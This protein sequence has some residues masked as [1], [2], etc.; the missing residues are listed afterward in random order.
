MRHTIRTTLPAVG[1]LWALVAAGPEAA[2][3]KPAAG[4]MKHDAATTGSSAVATEGFDAAKKVEASKDATEAKIQG[5]GLLSTGN[6]DSFAATGLAALR[7]RR[8]ENEFSASAAVNYSGTLADDGPDA[9]TVENYQGKVR[10]DRFL[11]EKVALFLSVSARRDRF[12]GLDLRMNFDPGV[13]YYFRDDETIAFWGELGYDYQY[14]VRRDQNLRDALPEVIDKTE[15]L[16]SARAFVGYRHKF[17]DS[18][19][20]NTGLEFLLGVPKT[21]Y[22]RLNWDVGLTAAIAERFSIATTFS[23]KYDNRPLPGVKKTDTLT[24]LNL[25]YTFF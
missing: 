6:A 8:A 4:T 15:T 16:H 23:L 9:T 7:L 21:E 18:V 1:A 13:A 5:G 22:W 11:T 12:Q 24:A 2:A 20:F 17:S 10:Y 14:D 3:Q 19:N 25:V